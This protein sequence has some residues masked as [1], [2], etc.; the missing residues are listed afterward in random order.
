MFDLFARLGL[1]STGFDRGLAA[2]ELRAGK[3]ASGI[4]AKL[5]GVFSVAAV[6]ALARKTIDFASNINDM[7]SALGVS[8]ERLQELDHAAK[9]NGTSLETMVTAMRKLAEARK[10][11]IE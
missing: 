9:L 4:G 6:T 11:A 1:N 2:A 3:F 10:K 8:A 5:A 7:S